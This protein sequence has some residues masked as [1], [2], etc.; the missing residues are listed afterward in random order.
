MSFSTLRTRII[1]DRNKVIMK[2]N[3]LKHTNHD[4]KIKNVEVF[5]MGNVLDGAN[6]R[7]IP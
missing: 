1:R 7:K 5:P 3:K 6:N 4:L 2:V